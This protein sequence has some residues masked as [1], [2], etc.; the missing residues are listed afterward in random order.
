MILN[1]IMLLIEETLAILPGIIGM[2][3]RYIY[4]CIFARECYYPIYIGQGSVLHGIR[5]ISLGNSV[6]IGSHCRLNAKGGKLIIGSDVTMNKNV[7]IEAGFGGVIIISDNVMI[8]A[9]VVMQSSEHNYG[10]VNKPMNKQ[11][12]RSGQI[13]VCPNVWICSNVV[14]T[15][16][17]TIGQGSIVGAGAVVTH[18][19]EPNSIVGGVPAKKI[20]ERGEVVQYGV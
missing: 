6:N 18:D 3:I 20:G 1:Q 4:V 16:D 15:S 10:D 8:G 7:Q 14:V 2:I 11:G 12:H 17:V 5:T 19:V 9:N 13:R